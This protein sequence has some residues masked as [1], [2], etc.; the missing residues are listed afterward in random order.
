MVYNDAV[1]AA[2]VSERAGDQA[3]EGNDLQADAREL[4]QDTFSWRDRRVA[5]SLNYNSVTHTKCLPVS[6]VAGTLDY[7]SHAQY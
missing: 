2:E 5:A 1:S 3:H 7:S 6:R 4:V